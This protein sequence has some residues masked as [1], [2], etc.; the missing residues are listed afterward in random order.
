MATLS[1]GVPTLLDWAKRLDASGVKVTAQIIELLSQRNAI[2]ADIPMVEGNLPTGTRTTL[3]SALPTVS[4]RRLNNGVT[5]SK[6]TT[7]QT[8]EACGL[9]EAW[10]EV[11]VKL[12]ELNGDAAGFRLSEAKA[13]LEAMSQKMAGTLFYGNA[14][15]NPEQFTGFAPRFAAISG[16]STA[17]NIISATASPSGSVQTSLWLIGWGPDTVHGIY[18][19]GSQQ[20]LQHHDLG[21]GVAELVAGL[22]NTRMRVYRDQFTWEFGLAVR[23]WRYVVR[24]ANVDTAKLVSQSGNADLIVT[25]SRMIDRLP[26]T[27]GVTPVFY[28]SRTPQSW[29][30]V[31]ALSKSTN[32]IAAEAGLDQFGRRIHDL[33][34][35]GIPIRT[36]D[37]ILE[38]EA[39]IS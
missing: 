5:P 10:A 17:K 11:D 12:A 33:T 13:F 35:S 20:G 34:F 30:R 26:S 7:K 21:I 6:S 14:G 38:T 4:F 27:N 37:Q 24:A 15:L 36:V 3:R 29:L 19:K 18:P 23:D 28:M 31:Q 1:T 22:G 25:M 32:A 16:G 8:D 2:L 39:I 9:M